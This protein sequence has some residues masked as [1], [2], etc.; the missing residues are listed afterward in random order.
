M[1]CYILMMINSRIF[2]K[3]YFNIGCKR[4]MSDAPNNTPIKDYL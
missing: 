1:N 2:L 4:N 3:F